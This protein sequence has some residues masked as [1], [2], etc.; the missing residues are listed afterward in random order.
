MKLLNRPAV[1]ILDMLNAKDGVEAFT[2]EDQE[3]GLK[4]LENIYDA[5]IMLVNEIIREIVK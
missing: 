2:K 1:I 5:K 4:Y 3:Q